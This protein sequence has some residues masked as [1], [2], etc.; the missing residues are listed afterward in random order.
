[1]AEKLNEWLRS[2]RDQGPDFAPSVFHDELAFKTGWGPMVSG[3][4]CFS[5]RK[6]R[7]NRG[8]GAAYFRPGFCSIA[9]GVLLLLAVTGLWIFLCTGCLRPMG[10]VLSSVLGL[11]IVG[12]GATLLYIHCCTRM[13][14][15][16]NHRL[17]CGRGAPGGELSFGSV[18]VIQLIF[19]W[20]LHRGRPSMYELNLVLNDGSRLN[21][22]DHFNFARM[23]AD[24]ETLSALLDVPIWDATRREGQ[25]S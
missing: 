25:E 17:L 16:L 6:L 21:L 12:T 24:A 11:A 5:T 19:S 18:H 2:L 20:N 22:V 23:R 3:F 1:M 7:V 14:F 10:I 13:V 8:S 4:G 9:R 15:D